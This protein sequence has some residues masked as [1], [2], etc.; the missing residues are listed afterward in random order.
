MLLTLVSLLQALMGEN[1]QLRSKLEEVKT[2]A[3]AAASEAA[4][5][6]LA[7]IAE[8]E[9]AEL[10]LKVSESNPIGP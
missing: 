5:H 3:E 4:G 6:L 9:T 8:R 10:N 7:V 1:A 2:G